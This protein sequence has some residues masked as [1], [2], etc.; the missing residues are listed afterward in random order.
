MWC[1]LISIK[2]ED[3]ELK[4]ENEKLRIREVFLQRDLR[5]IDQTRHTELDPDSYREK[6]TK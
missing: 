3:C 4:I 1:N 2:S 6:N 5:D